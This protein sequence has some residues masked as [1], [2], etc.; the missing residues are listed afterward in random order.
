MSENTNI[1]IKRKTKDR[2]D[3]FGK[4]SET[5]DKIIN[6]IL[7]ELERNRKVVTFYEKDGKW[8]YK[9]SEDGGETWSEERKLK[10]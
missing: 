8:F 4:H 9:I 7:D 1:K 3:N 6:R 10:K 2:L 5:Y